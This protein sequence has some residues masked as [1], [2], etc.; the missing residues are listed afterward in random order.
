[1]TNFCPSA[2]CFDET[3]F[4]KIHPGYELLDIQKD[5]IKPTNLEQTKNHYEKGNSDLATM[6]IIA[7]VTGALI[8][9][10]CLTSKLLCKNMVP[11]IK[12]AFYQIKTE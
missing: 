9:G 1:M 7:G 5:Y 10:S 11:K 6:L 3:L 8:L 12:Q 4:S 2:E